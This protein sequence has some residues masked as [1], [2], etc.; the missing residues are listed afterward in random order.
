MK[1]NATER[2]SGEEKDL[3]RRPVSLWNDKMIYQGG[4]I[5]GRAQPTR[6]RG[7]EKSNDFNDHYYPGLGLT[8]S[9]S[10]WP[11]RG[12][13][14]SNLMLARNGWVRFFEKDC[15]LPDIVP[16]LYP[17]SVKVNRRSGD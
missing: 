15:R 11:F 2:T 10:P 5:V 16:N 12:K 1:V 3:L 4:T 9:S 7:E 8:G 14:K 6:V 17:V 13:H